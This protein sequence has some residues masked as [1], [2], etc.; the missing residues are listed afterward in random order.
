MTEI[1]VHLVEQLPSNEKELCTQTCK[2]CGYHQFNK[3][4]YHKIYVLRKRI[5]ELRKLIEI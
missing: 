2:K 5:R 3:K 1:S 4:S